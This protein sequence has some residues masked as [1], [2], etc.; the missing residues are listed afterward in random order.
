MRVKKLITHRAAQ[1]AAVAALMAVAAMVLPGAAIARDCA[2]GAT[3]SP[4]ARAAT[5]QERVKDPA[6]WKPVHEAIIERMRL[7]PDA[8]LVFVGDSITAHFS[9]EGRFERL[10]GLAGRKALNLGVPGD[11]TE[12]VLWRLD[13][14]DLASLQP[15]EAVLLIGTN[16]LRG[17][18]TAC[19]ILAGIAAIVDRMRAAWP[20][21]RIVVLGIL[22]RGEGMRFAAER[23]RDV[24]DG[25][26][27]LAAGRGFVFVDTTEAFLCGGGNACGYFQ[28]DLL[29]LQPA[30]YE[31]YWRLLRP[32]LGGN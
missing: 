7:M 8:D 28:D 27:E 17:D 13:R 19:D 22:P 5:P 25:L 2:A 10:P 12:N 20:K 15:R 9:D 30:G 6:K 26:R 14:L 24:N 1:V 16:N 23:R 18:D 21:A 29:H 31:R 32:V 4:A 3:G 11:Q